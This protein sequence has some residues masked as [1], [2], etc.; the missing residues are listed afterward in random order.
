[1]RVDTWV[2][3]AHFC[4]SYSNK[5]EPYQKFNYSILG[6]RVNNK[7]YLKDSLIVLYLLR[8]IY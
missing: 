1:M 8:L 6:E 2:A 3:F 5:V 7:G 4:T